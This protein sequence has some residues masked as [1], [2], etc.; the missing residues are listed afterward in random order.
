KKDG[1][2]YEYEFE[3]A[4]EPARKIVALWSPTGEG[5]KG[6]TLVDLGG[7]TLAK[8]ERMPLKEGEVPAL[9]IAVR[10]GK[11]SVP[12]DES[13]IYLWLEPK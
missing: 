8:A 3:H 1:E 12:Y 2:L 10:D 9:P 11:V 7:L 13:P 6:E 5:K 4:K